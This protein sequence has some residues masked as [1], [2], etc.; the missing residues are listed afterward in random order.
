MNEFY[1]WLQNSLV[2]FN[3][4]FLGGHIILLHHDWEDDTG[5]INGTKWILGTQVADGLPYGEL[6][7]RLWNVVLFIISFSLHF[8]DSKFCAEGIYA[9]VKDR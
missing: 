4:P 8:E 2:S 3:L 9:T 5:A 6:H 1:C 7:P